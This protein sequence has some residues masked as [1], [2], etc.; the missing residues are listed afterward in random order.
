VAIFRQSSGVV[1]MSEKILLFPAAS[2]AGRKLARFARKLTRRE[3]GATAIEFGIVV[4]PFLALLFAIIEIA[5]VFFAGQVLE[6]AV[7]D[8]SR[9]ILTGQAQTGGFNQT[10]FKN[11]VC[12]R[13]YALFD[14]QANLKIDVQK[15]S[16][17]GG[18]NLTKPLDNNG[19]VD[20]SSFGYNPGAAC[21]IVIV[22]VVYEW[23]TFVRYFGLDMADLPN[24]KRL[25]MSTTA[26]R[27]EPFGA[28]PC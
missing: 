18:A 11:E 9:L 19:N 15:Y 5:L 4:I 27:N 21:D 28:T 23:S 26:F 13:L 16:S 10:Q 8:S 25:L 3:D 14:C 22:R 7:A 17:F 2:R 6:T 20:T 12:N 1:A 24:G